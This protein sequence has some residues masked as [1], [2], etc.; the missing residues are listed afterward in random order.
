MSTTIQE[1][2]S[3]PEYIDTFLK[4]NMVKLVGNTIK[5]LKNIKLVV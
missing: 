4:A 1:A 2:H 3:T 5:E